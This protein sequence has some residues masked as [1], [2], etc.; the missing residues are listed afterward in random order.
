MLESSNTKP[1][2]HKLYRWLVG[3][4]GIYS[5]HNPYSLNSLKGGYIGD[6]VEDYYR[7]V[8]KGDTRSLDYG[9]YS[10]FRIHSLIPYWPAKSI[11]LIHPQIGTLSQK[12]GTLYLVGSLTHSLYCLPP[13]SLK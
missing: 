7:G 13:F 8:I 10:P 12:P 6:Y 4:K 3:K 9:S 1:L 11:T 5:P 2:N